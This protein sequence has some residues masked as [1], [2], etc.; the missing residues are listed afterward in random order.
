ML[1]SPVLGLGSLCLCVSL[2]IHSDLWPVRITEEDNVYAL[3]FYGF[4]LFGAVCIVSLPVPVFSLYWG[5]F[6]LTALAVI[7]LRSISDLFQVPAVLRSVS[8][9]IFGK[10]IYA[11]QLCR[12]VS[13]WIQHFGMTKT[14][15]VDP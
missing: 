11:R 15:N 8:G 5:L 3:N 6:G 10:C 14:S 7:I 12:S 2:P 9:H 4:A 1:V 13:D